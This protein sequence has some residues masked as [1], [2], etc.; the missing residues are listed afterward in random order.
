[1]TERMI[2]MDDETGRLNQD[3]L[4]FIDFVA[5]KQRKHDIGLVITDEYRI[6]DIEK[7]ADRLE[8]ENPTAAQVLER[9]VSIIAQ[10]TGAA[11]EDQVG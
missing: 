11:S 8:A 4:P 7:S 1:M 2:H 10:T 5:A 9:A 3:L 6:E